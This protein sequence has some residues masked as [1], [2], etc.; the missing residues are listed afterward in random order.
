MQRFGVPDQ[1]NQCPTHPTLCFYGHRPNDS[2]SPCPAM[3]PDWKEKHL[4]P[5]VCQLPVF[6][7]G[8]CRLYGSKEGSN[9]ISTRNPQEKRIYCW[10]GLN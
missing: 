1:P 3:D 10:A 5:T 8:S 6:L 2:N 7:D 9:P 4:Y